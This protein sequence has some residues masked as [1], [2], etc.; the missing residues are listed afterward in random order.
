VNLARDLDSP[1]P[2]A[3]LALRDQ[4]SSLQGLLVLS[5]LMTEYA[6]EEQI[7]H[8]ATTAVPSMGGYRL[9]GVFLV[10]E[11]WPIAA[12]ACA[13]ADV[14]A[15]VEV[16][17]DALGVS[18][19]AV[20]IPTCAWGSALPLRSLAG[21]FG[22]LL[23]SA[24]G[25]PA[26]WEQFLVRA[27]AQQSGIALGNARLLERQRAASKELN[28]ANASL[29]ETIAALEHKTAIHD[30]L[31][32]VAVAGEGQE[33]IARAVYDLT[34]YPVAVEDRHGN[35]RA[36]AGPDCPDPYPK[37]APANRERLLQRAQDEGRPIRAGERF[38]AVA[39]FRNEIL[40][41]LAL[42]VTAAQ[43][44]NEEQVAL[45][46][47]ATLLGMELFRLR[48]LAEA[49]L[50][51]GGD[52]LEDLLI[53][54]DE[55]SARTR[56]EA[57]GHDLE[58]QHRVVVVERPQPASDDE[59]F[60]HTVRRAARDFGLGSILCSRGGTIVVLSDIEQPWGPFRDAVAAELGDDHCRVG[61]GSVCRASDVPNSYREAQL[62][63]K[64]QHAS[65]TGDRATVFDELGIYRIFAHVEEPAE[66]ERFAR[67][68]L[69]ALL[70]YDIKKGSQLVATLS[71]FLECG[72]HYDA[73]CKVLAIGRSTLKYRLQRI[74]ELSGHDLSNPDTRFNLQLATRA[75][76]A[77]VGLSG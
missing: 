36:W 6:D 2:E 40:G 11:G 52:F 47:G 44:G 7:L 43:A 23:V 76:H 58:H 24:D 14:R 64:L 27:L 74:R 45:E 15:R 66:I 63:L 57:L 62:A 70:E 39:G 9:E 20:A 48:S 28:A 19:G 50:R 60:F 29:G 53:G 12:G 67:E 68:W 75:R 49:E 13:A 38:I 22:F 72:G 69:G 71:T 51:L 31:T 59:A 18:G 33:G 8:L 73:T 35:L 37:D 30:R 26:P 32:Q 17:L 56:A 21:H 4:L 34:G 77:L 61:V 46:H 25:E 55:E 65:T 10:G 16:Q 3:D 5:M 41:V 42:V 54:I 1:E